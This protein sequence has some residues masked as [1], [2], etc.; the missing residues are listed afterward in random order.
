MI[1]AVLLTILKVIGIILLFILGILLL[2]IGVVL[3]IPIVYQCKASYDEQ[4]TAKGKISWLFQLISFQFSFQDGEFN[5]QIRIFI[6]LKNKDETESNEGAMGQ[7]G[8]TGQVGLEQP[9][10][11]ARPMTTQPQ[12]VHTIAQEKQQVQERV[13]PPITSKELEK[14]SEERKRQMAPLKKIKDIKEVKKITIKPVKRKLPDILEK[15]R[16]IYYHPQRRYALHRLK[17]L[18]D[19]LWK[20]IKPKKLIVEAEFGLEDPSETGLWLGRIYSIK[21][22]VD[23]DLK[24]FIQGNFDEAMFQGKGYIKGRIYGFYLLYIVIKCLR[25]KKLMSF[26]KY[27]IKVFQS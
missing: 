23:P 27:G 13:K 3:F 24:I 19:K 17:S 1:G 5:Q 2:V 4:L 7:E 14:V 25:D 12:K 21:Y 6:K 11:A 26:V 18:L 16:K 9:E 8:N 15:L 10:A 22:L 20:H